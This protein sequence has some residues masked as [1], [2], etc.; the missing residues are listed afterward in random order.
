ML[1]AK[2]CAKRENLVATK[3]T[4]QIPDRQTKQ[5]TLLTGKVIFYSPTEGL[6][7]CCIVMAKAQLSSWKCLS[8]HSTIHSFIHSMEIKWTFLMVIFG[9]NENHWVH[10]HGALGCCIFTIY[11]SSLAEAQL[12]LALT[13]YFQSSHPSHPTKCLNT[14]LMQAFILKMLWRTDTDPG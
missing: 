9:R 8:I 2:Q 7:N 4:L 6:C 1:T 5:D 11:F 13:P 3:Y 10:F 12:F 14:S